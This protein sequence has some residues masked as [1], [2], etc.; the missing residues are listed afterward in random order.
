MGSAKH[1]CI[2]SGTRDSKRLACRPESRALDVDLGRLANRHKRIALAQ[3]QALRP[4]TQ[5][6]HPPNNSHGPGQ[7]NRWF[8]P[9]V[10]NQVVHG[11]DELVSAAP[12]RGGLHWRKHHCRAGS[13]EAAGK[14]QFSDARR[15]VYQQEVRPLRQLLKLLL[16]RDQGG[17]RTNST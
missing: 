13:V 14:G 9:A 15:F 8:T 3:Q 17:N 2:D 4:K 12:S 1:F 16:V 6:V 7:E 5:V 10:I 11:R